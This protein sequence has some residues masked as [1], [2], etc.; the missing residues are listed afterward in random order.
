MPTIQIVSI[1][2]SGE[3]AEITF[4]P[5]SGGTINLGSQTIPYNYTTD[6]YEGVYTLYYP[7][8]NTTCILDIP[9]LTPTPTPTP[10]PTSTPCNDVPISG[11]TTTMQTFATNN[12]VTVTSDPSGILYQI[13]N[14]GTGATPTLSSTVSVRYTARLMNSTIFDSVSGTPVSL[15]LNSL[16]QS[17]Q[18]ALQL[19]QAGGRIKFISPSSLAYGCEGAGSIPP[20]SPLF[21]DVELVSVS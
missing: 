11:E 10:T 14:S 19:I 7:V 3:T 18:V 9:C 6:S 20:D 21:F 8:H 17:W 5:C 13:I 15:P 16:I 12:G 2:F 1:N 4:N